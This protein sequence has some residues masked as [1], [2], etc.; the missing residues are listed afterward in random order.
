[1]TADEQG[2]PFALEEVTQMPP[3]TD[4]TPLQLRYNNHL[5]RNEIE[6]DGEWIDVV[7]AANGI[8]QNPLLVGTHGATMTEM[9]PG[10]YK[11]D[12]DK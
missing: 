6:V 2:V 9:V 5:Q 11:L 7:E 1:M 4:A 8:D 3:R 12:D 10:G